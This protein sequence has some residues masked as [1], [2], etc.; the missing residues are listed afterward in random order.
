MCL[1]IDVSSKQ[2]ANN[3]ASEAAEGDW[4]YVTGGNNQQ[5]KTMG[6]LYFANLAIMGG[7]LE[8]THDSVTSVM[9]KCQNIQL[10]TIPYRSN[11]VFTS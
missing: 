7:H 3:N 11:C 4:M 9:A 8:T 2:I 5:Q 1:K 6:V 10:V